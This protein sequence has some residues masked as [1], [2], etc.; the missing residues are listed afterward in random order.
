MLNMRPSNGSELIAVV[1]DDVSL[2]NALVLLLRAEGYRVELYV[3]AEQFLTSAP[4]LDPRCVLIDIDLGSASGLSM[5]R[6]LRA[7]GFS[8]P[9]IFMTGSLEDALSAQSAS[10]GGVALLRKPFGHKHLMDTI[11]KTRHPARAQAEYTAGS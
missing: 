4:F 2:G 11:A 3:S 8:Y 9:M 1:E 6:E 10:S 5:A 7:S